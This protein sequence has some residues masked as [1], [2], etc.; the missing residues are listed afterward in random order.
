MDSHITQP[1]VAAVVVALAL[2]VQEA[3]EMLELRGRRRLQFLE[4]SRA[5]VAATEEPEGMPG[6]LETPAVAE[7]VV[8]LF[9]AK[10]AVTLAPEEEA[11][12]L[13]EAAEIRVVMVFFRP[14]AVMAAR[15]Q[16]RLPVTVVAAA[17]AASH[18]VIKQPPVA[19]EETGTARGLAAV[20]VAEVP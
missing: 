5:A 11:A 8:K 19:E 9:A 18:K 13:L 14:M 20:A 3:P 2:E 10:V 12:V 4:T 1:V 17:P 7:M 15:E 6:L 16:A